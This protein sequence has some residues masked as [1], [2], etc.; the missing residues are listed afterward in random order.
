MEKKTL[1]VTGAATGLTAVLGTLATSSGTSSSWYRAL[2]KPSIQPP[3]AVF[4]LVWTALYTDIAISSAVALNGLAAEKGDDA[5]GRARGYRWALGV[6]L[7]LNATWS[8][9]FFRWHRLGTAVVVA[10]ALAVSS[11]DLARRA[12]ASSPAAALALVPYAAWCGFATALSA[13]LWRGNR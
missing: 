8:W 10:G 2:R 4:P 9:T 11:L 7:V 13:A 12:R 3:A 5:P 1:A 6:N